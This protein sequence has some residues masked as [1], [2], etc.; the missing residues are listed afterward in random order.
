MEKIGWTMHGSLAWGDQRLAEHGGRFYL[1]DRSGPTPDSTDDGPLYIDFGD[2]AVRVDARS[3]SVPV[4]GSDGSHYW[5]GVTHQGMLRLRTML[6][7]KSVRLPVRIEGELLALAAL[8]AAC[9][10]DAALDAALASQKG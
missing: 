4:V 6:A 5:V 3:C 7:A 1:F 2:R 10:A 8:F 9:Q